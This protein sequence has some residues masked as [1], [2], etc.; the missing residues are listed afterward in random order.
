MPF[1]SAMKPIIRNIREN[2]AL[3]PKRGRW[4]GAAQGNDRSLR[5]A[6]SFF[7]R[8]SRFRSPARDLILSCLFSMAFFMIKQPLERSKRIMIRNE[9]AMVSWA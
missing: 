7:L 6:D 2:D 5:R 4:A 9:Q 1:H 3:D 8:G